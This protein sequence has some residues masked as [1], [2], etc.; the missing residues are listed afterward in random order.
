[1]SIWLWVVAVSLAVYWS[2]FFY[3]LT[4]RRWDAPAL[5]VGVLHMLF[6]SI[7]V[8]VPIRSFFDPNYIG[9]GVGLVRFEGRWATLPSAVLLSWALAAAWFAVSYGKGRWMKLIAVGDILFALNLGGGFLL[10]YVRGDLSAS[11]IQGGEFFTLRG[12]V[13]A[14]IPLLMFALPFVASAIWAMRRVEPDGTAPPSAQGTQEK[15]ADSEKETKDI[16]GF[17]YSASRI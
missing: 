13:A 9:F 16:N 6:A 10:D 2:I 8:A 11:K 4:R 3:L 1:M 12:T 14:L 5:I 7:F 15:G 17:R